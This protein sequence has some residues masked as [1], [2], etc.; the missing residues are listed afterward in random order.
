MDKV[1][2]IVPVYN[3][4]KCML[5]QCFD[6]ILDQTYKNIELIIVDDG[7]NRDIADLCDEYRASHSHFDIKVIHNENGGASIARNTG[8]DIST[9]E[10]ITF[11]DADDWIDDDYIEQLHNKIVKLNADIVMCSRVLEFK[12]NSKRDPFF[13]QDIIFDNQ[14][15]RNLIRKSITT[16]VAGTWCK[17]YKSTFLKKNNLKY[18][19]NL[20][21]TQDIIFNLYAFQAA[22]II[23]YF[24]ISIYH[25][26]MQNK[27][28]TK[29]YNSNADTVLTRAAIEFRNFADKFY[30]GDQDILQDVYY[31]CLIILNEILKLKFFNSNYQ[32]KRKYK[33]DK[34]EYLLSTAVYS[35]AIR[36]INSKRVGGLMKLR[37][38]FIKKRFYT[39]LELFYYFQRMVEQRR[40]YS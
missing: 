7:S 30:A 4:E 20:R 29:K 1:S 21:R 16:G 28:I 6:S 24:N 26:R 2:I 5:I 31:K 36:K 32:K 11:V 35:E 23:G 40:N 14:N 17:L 9:G 3:V 10:Y 13:D 15:K 34:I 33:Y 18:D 8:I 39:L 25:Y 27:S 22:D 19:E 12:S 37:I 38:F